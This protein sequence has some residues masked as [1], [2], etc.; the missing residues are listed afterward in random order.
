MNERMEFALKTRK[1]KREITD[2]DREKEVFENI[3]RYPTDL[4]K[5]DFSKKIFKEIMSESKKLQKM[6]LKLMGFQ[7]E[8]G[9][10]S[11]VASGKY[12]SGF[13]SIPCTEFINIFHGIEE[14]ILDLGIL[15]VE[16]TQ[17]GAV[18]E[19][20][21]LLINL[22]NDFQIVGEV[23]VR[24]NHCLLTLPET[25]YREIKIV[26]SH[27]QALAQCRG[28]ISRNKLEQRP[29]YD[30]AGAAKMLSENRPRA[31]A[32]IAS[33][34]CTQLYNLEIIKENIEDESTNFTRFI[35]I[36]KNSVQADGDKCSIVFSTQHKAGALF[37]ILEMFS[38]A[39]VNLTRIESRPIRNNPGNYAFLLDFKGSD[40]DE[41]VSQILSKIKKK[42]LMYKF[43]GCYKEA[44]L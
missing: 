2:A 36:S 39:N 44:Q 10:N 23:K 15:P 38:D 34:M 13:V 28:F 21:D 30:T 6:D 26:Y 42:T 19:V 35:V 33:K 37:K 41:K 7:G 16:N 8:H 27:P 31:V 4:I 20:N 22:D 14:N 3:M 43:L 18:T 1:L 9:A 17:E 25:N 32:V 12:K 29:F 24:I 5:E 40:K 11:E